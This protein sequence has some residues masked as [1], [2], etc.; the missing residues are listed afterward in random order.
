M[1][2]KVFVIL[3]ETFFLSTQKQ[4]QKKRTVPTT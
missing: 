3:H 2:I 1:K 4:L